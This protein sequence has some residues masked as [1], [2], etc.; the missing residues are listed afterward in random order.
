M[1]N[2]KINNEK[3]CEKRVVILKSI[4][5]LDA[6]IFS[7][8]ASVYFSGKRIISFQCVFRRHYNPKIRTT[9]VVRRGLSP[10]P[11]TFAGEAKSQQRR[12]KRKPDP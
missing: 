3:E 5:P 8:N 6:G 2:A 1:G 9:A 12:L 7:I 10:E 11:L 4:H